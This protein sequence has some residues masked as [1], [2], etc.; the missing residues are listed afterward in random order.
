M[1]MVDKVLLV[2]WVLQVQQVLECKEQLDLAQMEEMVQLE[3]KEIKALLGLGQWAQL[4][5]TVRKARQDQV[6][7]VQLAQE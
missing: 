6:H 2:R 3:R 5:Q 4:A 1:R 7:K